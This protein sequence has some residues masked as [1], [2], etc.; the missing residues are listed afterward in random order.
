MSSKKQLNIRLD[1]DLRTK[2]KL[3]ALLKNQTINDYIE[4]SI[5]KTVEKD[6]K[7]IEKLK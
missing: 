4:E 3:I 7:I 2:I 5:K 6:K 1:E